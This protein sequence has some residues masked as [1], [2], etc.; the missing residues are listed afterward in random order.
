MGRFAC[1]RALK[2]DKFGGQP[3]ALKA[4]VPA[5]TFGYQDFPHRY[6]RG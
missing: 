3:R 2:P 1:E 6:R 4:E 5:E